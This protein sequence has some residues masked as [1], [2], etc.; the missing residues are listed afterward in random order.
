MLQ[1]RSTQAIGA[2][3]ICTIGSLTVCTDAI[4]TVCGQTIGAYMV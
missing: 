3:A 1:G 4:C 2:Y